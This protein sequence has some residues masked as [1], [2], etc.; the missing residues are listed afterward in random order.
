MYKMHFHNYTSYI[1][2]INNILLCVLLLKLNNVS[3]INYGSGS[4]LIPLLNIYICINIHM[5]NYR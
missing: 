5:A 1:I 2:D 4:I 3:Y